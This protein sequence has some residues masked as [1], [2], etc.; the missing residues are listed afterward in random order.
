ML[1]KDEFPGSFQ[2]TSQKKRR[3]SG[4]SD[5]SPKPKGG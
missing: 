5:Q 1:Q 2:R 4:E 3:Q